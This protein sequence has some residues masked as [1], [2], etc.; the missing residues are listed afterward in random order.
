MEQNYNE[1]QAIRSTQIKAYANGG[2]R[3]LWECTYGSDDSTTPS[4]QFGS[5]AHLRALC[6]EKWESEVLVES[7]DRRTKEGK[8]RAAEIE[9]SGKIVVKPEEADKI[10]R[11]A[12]EWSKAVLPIL[13]GGYKTEQVFVSEIDGVR[14]KA[15]IDAISNDNKIVVDYKS[16]SDITQAEREI[17]KRRYDLQLG[18]YTN[19]ISGSI[20]EGEFQVYL[21]FVETGS[22]YRRRVF[23]LT[24]TLNQT[25]PESFELAKNC[26]SALKTFG[27]DLNQWPQPGITVIEK[28]PDWVRVSVD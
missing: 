26:D 16:I 2:L 10:E 13:G 28:I 5:M 25:R 22:P 11:M 12:F 4:L 14:I 6:S 17:W 9:A 19:S 21:V 27:S 3:G 7:I 24:A 23:D 8:A 1:I 15:Q 20:T 18:H